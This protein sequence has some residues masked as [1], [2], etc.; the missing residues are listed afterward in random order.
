[1][2]TTPIADGAALVVAQSVVSLAE[3]P[4][5]AVDLESARRAPAARHP[6]HVAARILLRRLLAELFGP[7]IVTS[8]LAA[9]ADGQPHLVSDPE[10]GI[11]L[12]HTPGWAAAAIRPHGVIGV[13][14][15]EPVPV[16]DRLVRRVTGA[17][18]LATLRGRDQAFRDLETA[19]IW[20]V[21]EA[22]VKAEGTGM[23]GR[24]WTVPVGIGQ[25]RG[26]WRGFGWR[27]GRDLWP[28]PVSWA[29]RDHGQG[30]PSW[31]G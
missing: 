25:P 26:H 6:D 21:Q 7:P 13:D 24:P 16:S 22:C 10:I 29:Q 15:Q 3:A 19:W 18:W 8:A 11:S 9:S 27:A 23:T 30:G 17:A 5:L 31:P 14:V 28:V 12:S 1:M 2:N 20:T 4:V